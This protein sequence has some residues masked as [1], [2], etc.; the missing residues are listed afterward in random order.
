VP[1]LLISRVK[2]QEHRCDPSRYGRLNPP[3]PPPPKLRGSGVCMCVGGVCHLR[4]G[5]L[6]DL[7]GLHLEQLLGFV[8][9]RHVVLLRFPHTGSHSLVPLLL[10]LQRTSQDVPPR[11]VNCT[12][13]HVCL[14]LSPKDLNAQL[15]GPGNLI[16]QLQSQPIIR[17]VILPSFP[18]AINI[19]R[20]RGV[21]WWI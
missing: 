6:L 1:K 21:M 3:P 4:G 9:L 13:P 7:D 8:H 19:S 18:H 15:P 10:L 12:R 5:C 16:A 2:R 20:S 11:T 14:L 17:H